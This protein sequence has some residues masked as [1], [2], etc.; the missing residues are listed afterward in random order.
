MSE[1]QQAAR[2]KLLTIVMPAMNEQDNLTRAYELD[3]LR[4]RSCENHGN[5]DGAW[6]FWEKP[7]LEG[8]GGQAVCE[9][10]HEVVYLEFE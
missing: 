4:E 3:L 7:A 9:R 8:E 5:Q 10:I 6:N 2:R 1:V